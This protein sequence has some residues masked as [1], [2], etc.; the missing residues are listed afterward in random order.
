MN[1]FHIDYDKKIIRL[2]FEGEQFT[3]NLDDGDIGDFWHSFT[4][5]YGTMKDINFSQEDETQRP[6]LGVYGVKEVEGQMQV[7]TNDSIYITKCLKFGDAKNYFDP[8]P[9]QPKE[10]NKGDD[11]ETVNKAVNGYI[12]DYYPEEERK[13]IEK[14][15][16]NI[17]ERLTK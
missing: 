1:T 13:V 7:D 12:D 15:W 14:A 5:G 3:F 4:T 11:W 8:Q 17:T 16:K 2:L 9:V 6:C 10:D